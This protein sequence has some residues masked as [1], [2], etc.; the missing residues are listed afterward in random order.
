MSDGIRDHYREHGVTNYYLQQ[1]GEYNNPHFP[2]IEALLIKNE[3]RIDYKRV[4]DFCCGSGEVSVVIEHLGY[5]PPVACD[6]YTKEAFTKRTGRTCESWSFE[7]VVK[8]E[9]KGDY[10]AV[11]CSFAMHLCPEEQLF[12]LAYQLFQHT[13]LLVILT[14]H[15]RPVLEKFEGIYLAF[16]DHELTQ[17]GKKVFLKA[18]SSTFKQEE[19]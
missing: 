2:Q 4:L 3:H 17:R 15:K 8:G 11:I 13:G 19:C 1:G 14:P 16:D 10:S 12:P 5:P 9:L 7:S 18:Y 6:P